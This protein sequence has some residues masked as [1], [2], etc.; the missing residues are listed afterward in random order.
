[1][2]IRKTEAGYT[3]HAWGLPPGPALPT[4]DAALSKAAPFAIRT[5]LEMGLVRGSAPV[6]CECVDM[7][8]GSRAILA[9]AVFLVTI[10]AGEPRAVWT[11]PA[12]AAAG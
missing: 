10:G 9:T 7:S 4:L 8:S 11:L 3:F 1:M 12:L 5:A 6:E 2:E